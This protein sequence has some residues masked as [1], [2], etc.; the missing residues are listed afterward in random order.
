M[1]APKVLTPQL[2]TQTPPLTCQTSDHCTTAFGKL[3]ISIKLYC[4]IRVLY[5]CVM[6]CVCRAFTAATANHARLFDVT[7]TYTT[8]PMVKIWSSVDVNNV[9]RTVIIHKDPN[10]TDLCS[11]TLS[12]PSGKSFSAAATLSRMAPAADGAKAEYGIKFAGQTF[13]GSQDGKPL[14]LKSTETVDVTKN[15]YAFYVAPA[16]IVILEYPSPF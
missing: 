8:N 9:A 16:S 4:Q 5:C 1:A 15:Q 10:A 6:C 14:G 7:I 12:P 2:R 13:D 11:V 3:H